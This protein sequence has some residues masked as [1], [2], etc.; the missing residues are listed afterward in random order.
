MGI[1]HQLVHSARHIC[2]DILTDRVLC[3]STVSNVLG[4][5]AVHV[6]KARLV[7]LRHNHLGHCPRGKSIKSPADVRNDIEN[8]LLAGRSSGDVCVISIIWDDVALLGLVLAVGL[9]KHKALLNGKQI[10][11]GNNAL[12]IGINLVVEHKLLVYGTV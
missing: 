9:V 11:T 2:N 1:L 5:L 6:V 10:S 7:I 4:K 12:T 3:K 8:T